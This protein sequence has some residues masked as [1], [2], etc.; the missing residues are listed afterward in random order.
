MAAGTASGYGHGW[1]EGTLVLRL[2]RT[3]TNTGAGQA[4]FSLSRT[5]FS[6]EREPNDEVGTATT[7]GALAGTTVHIIGDVAADEVDHFVF[8]LDGPA[9]VTIASQEFGPAPSEGVIVTL[10]DDALEPSDDVFPTLTGTLPAGEHI[11]RVRAG[12]AGGSYA[13]S[14]RVVL[15]N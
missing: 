13:L 12:G 8:S 15:G 5:G 9:Q 4:D 3:D 2:T 7:M 6:A 1:A 14:T 10:I 11:V